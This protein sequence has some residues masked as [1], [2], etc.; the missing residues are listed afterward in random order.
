[1]EMIFKFREKVLRGRN[2]IEKPLQLEAPDENL[3]SSEIMIER[4]DSDQ[5]F[6]PPPSSSKSL[7]KFWKGTEVRRGAV[8]NPGSAHK[9]VELWSRN[10]TRLGF[11][12][13]PL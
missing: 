6:L 10:A 9:K 5:K 11:L 8:P 2:L 7:K 4:G 3:V 12:G 1:M 13:P